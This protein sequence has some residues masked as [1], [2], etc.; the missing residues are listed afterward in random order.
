MQKT[1][2]FFPGQGAQQR[3]MLHDFYQAEPIVQE[4]FQIAQAALGYDL[5]DLI[6]NDEQKLNETQFTQPALLAS[7]YAIW[8]VIQQKYHL[9]PSVLAGHSLGEYSALV[10]AE[11]LEFTDAL[12]LVEKR[13]HL[14]QQAVN[15]RDCAMSA[16]L[17]L[18]DDQVKQ[19]CQQASDMGIVEPANF[20]SKGQVVISG[21]KAAVEK[22][23]H[24]AKEMGAK[25]AQLLAVSVPSH[26]SLMRSAAEAFQQHLTRTPIETPTIPIIHNY[27]VIS[28]SQPD[29]IRDVLVKQLFNPV[30]WT[31]TVEHCH[32]QIH[33][34][35]FIECGPNK[36][37]TGLGKRIAKGATHLPMNQYTA[38]DTIES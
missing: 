7:S 36:V 28:H 29:A 10:C 11:S 2:F 16:I 22:A 3:G 4:T 18:S 35:R 14:M 30:Q 37:L 21:E 17:G 27:D 5:W 24:L 19:C 9:T 1:A 32:S 13:G 26:C 6:Q 20:N 8:R 38:L 33:I 23:N 34:D 15:D 12:K 25:R 31:Q